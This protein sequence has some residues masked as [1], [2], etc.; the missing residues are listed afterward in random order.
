MPTI[1]DKINAR[2][3][4]V[5]LIHDSEIFQSDKKCPICGGLVKIQAYVGEQ[6]E[7]GLWKVEKVLWDCVLKH[8]QAWNQYEEWQHENLIYPYPQTRAFEKELIDYLNS[9]YRVANDNESFIDR[10]IKYQKSKQ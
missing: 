1:N 5:E 7:F 6:D 3:L 10:S 4:G 9:K 2:I 8:N